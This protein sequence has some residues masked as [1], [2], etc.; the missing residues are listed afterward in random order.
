MIKFGELYKINFAWD[1]KTVLTVRV[2][3]DIPSFDMATIYVYKK[4]KDF[5]VL[6]FNQNYVHLIS[7]RREG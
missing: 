4:Y 2:N 5:L 3:N 7:Y 1:D 6:M